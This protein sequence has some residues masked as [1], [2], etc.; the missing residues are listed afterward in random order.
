MINEFLDKVRDNLITRSIM[1]TVNFVQH[2][3]ISDLIDEPLVHIETKV[4]INSDL[5]S[6]VNILPVL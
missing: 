3:L 4:L 6:Y 1:E 2:K 5:I